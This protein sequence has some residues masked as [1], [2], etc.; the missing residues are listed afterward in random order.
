MELKGR[1]H[2]LIYEYTENA[3][4]VRAPHR[5]RHLELV[6]DWKRDGRLIAGGATGD[7]PSG[8]LIVMR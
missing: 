1:H 4:E 7:P 5:D 8:A 6:A 3:V 2:V